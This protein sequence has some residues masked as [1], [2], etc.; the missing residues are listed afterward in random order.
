MKPAN[1]S[2]QFLKLTNSGEYNIRFSNSV[3]NPLMVVMGLG[4]FGLQGSITSNV[5][6]NV[7]CLD[8][9][10][11]NFLTNTIFGADGFGIIQFTGNVTNL[12]LIF[13]PPTAQPNVWISFGVPCVPLAT[14]TPTPNATL[15]STP[16]PAIT[17]TSTM[18][19]T[20]TNTQTVTKS[21]TPTL[22]LTSSPNSSPTQTPTNTFTPT[23]TLTRTPT[24]TYS[25]TPLPT[26]T[27]TCFGS[28]QICSSYRVSGGTP[29]TIV[30]YTYFDCNTG[31]AITMLVVGST[32]ATVCSRFTPVWSIIAGGPSGF[33][34]EISQGCGTYCSSL[35]ATLTP[36]PTRTLLS[37][38]TPT[39]TRT[40]TPSTTSTQ[41]P[42]VTP[43]M[44]QTATPTSSLG[45]TPKPTPTNTVSPTRTITPTPSSTIPGCE[46][47]EYVILSPP[48]GEAPFEITWTSCF[49]NSMLT[50]NDP[51]AW[52]LT[53]D[54]PIP[55][56][57]NLTA[58][59]GSV[60]IL[61][62]ISEVMVS[63]GAAGCTCFEF[64]I[65]STEYNKAC[66]NNVF[67]WYQCCTGEIL[68]YKVTNLNFTISALKIY[69]VIG[70]ST[71]CF[72]YQ[73]LPKSVWVELGDS[74]VTECGVG[75]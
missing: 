19:M 24:N 45:S 65:N 4:S 29:G 72:T 31:S 44:T 50:L 71:D 12:T 16:I 34:V 2:Q 75:C 61:P 32:I 63:G 55:N 11:L 53:S 18:T 67:V 68:Q 48:A 3:A 17:P 59:F 57:F 38:P 21:S 43:T 7:N 46:C 49:N 35:S 51:S 1:E 6:F 20:N 9:L 23:P 8:N 14:P 58:C 62:E 40:S 39:P 56:P 33:S 70:L 36:T 52:T 73:R 26:V 54:K 22:S 41:T 60:S 13:T 66:R 47:V 28:V 30:T 5:G 10:T 25:N 15:S 27:S 64:F 42:T 69:S 37:T 74:G